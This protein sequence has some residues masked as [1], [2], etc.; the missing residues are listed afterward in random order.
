MTFKSIIKY[1]GKKNESIILSYSA[2]RRLIGICGILLPLIN[3]LGGW[4][5]TNIPVQ[6]TISAY[7]YTNM[8]DFFTGLM[9][10]VSIFLITYKG[11][12]VIDFVITTITGVMGLGVAIFPCYNELF[13]TQ[14]VGIFQLITNTSDKIHLTCAALFFILLAINSIF[15]FTRTN[16]EITT[17]RKK[18]RNSVY[19]GCGIIILICVTSNALFTFILSN[20]QLFK[21][22]IIL[23]LE[24][25]ALTAFGISWLIKGKTL[26]TDKKYEN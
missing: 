2:L 3:I 4:S 12:N 10:V 8:R 11:Y 13:K 23:I 9:F 18:I 24:S 16:K 26:L 5:I 1:L 7:Y 22:K 15:L 25:V 6:E 20:D 14:T 21:S 19:R 17:S